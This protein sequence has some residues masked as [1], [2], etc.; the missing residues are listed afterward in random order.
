MGHLGRATPR[1][2]TLPDAADQVV[3][4][5]PKVLAPRASTG[6][7]PR[8]RCDKALTQALAHH[9]V[10]LVVAPAGYGKTTMVADWARQR[11][12]PPAWLSLDAG[13]NDQARL[14][15]AL[16]Q[17]LAHVGVDVNSARAG[18]GID[19]VLAALATAQPGLVLVV[20]DVQELNPATMT[21]V[22]SPL[23]RFAP[24]AVRLVLV[25]RYDPAGIPVNKLRTQG[26]LG[27]VRR[28]DLAFTGSEITALARAER[29]RVEGAAAEELR[30]L[31][32]GWAVAVRL[33]L[34][35]L[36]PDHDA[37]TQIRVLRHL[38]VHINEYLVQEVLS[39]LDR[40][41]TDFV[42]E[43]T[44]CAEITPGLAEELIP[45]GARRLEECLARGLFL[46]GPTR[47]ADEPSYR[48]NPC[49]RPTAE[50]S[51]PGAAREGQSG[52]TS[53]QRATCS[54]ATPNL[55]SATPCAA[56]T[57]HSRC[58]S[59][60]TCGRTWWSSDPPGGFGPCAA[61]CH[62]RSTK[63]PRSASPWP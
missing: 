18:E 56:P 30:T 1:G 40:P 28:H 52:Y 22:L 35:S 59:S 6:A 15:T 4:T 63:T 58:R 45:D 42:L 16:T 17:A 12:A 8:D 33:A 49:S 29:R 43:A 10:V 34:L 24:D 62:P 61:S 60:P 9:R 20:D 38:D 46:S 14:V 39:Q 27:E 13:D 2:V 41:L 36:H 23:V 3:A 37:A 31:T 26:E 51:R 54:A 55:P 25:S 50:P 21:L 5:N 57:S 53:R 32:D 44:G 7:I 11:S 47:P 19:R 48:W